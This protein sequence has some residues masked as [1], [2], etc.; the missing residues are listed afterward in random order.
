LKRQAICCLARWDSLQ[1]HLTLPYAN[2][3]WEARKENISEKRQYGFPYALT[4]S[5]PI[6]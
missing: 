6:G 1:K 3:V 5:E 4:I 2:L